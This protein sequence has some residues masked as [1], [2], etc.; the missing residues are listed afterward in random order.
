MIN[1]IPASGALNAADSPAAAPVA[2]NVCRASALRIRNRSPTMRPTLPPSCTVGPSRPS[3]M[4]A[5][6]V[7]IPP[8]NFT[9]STRHQRTGRSSSSAPSISGIPEPPAS[10]AN[11]RTRK[12]P[13]M[14]NSAE[15]PKAHTQTSH[16]RS[17]K[18]AT[19]P[20]RQLSTALTAFS[21]ATPTSPAS[22]PTT[23][24][25]SRMANGVLSRLSSRRIL[26]RCFARVNCCCSKEGVFSF[27]TC[28]VSS[29]K[30][31]QGFYQRQSPRPLKNT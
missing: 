7:P 19:V 5:P 31:P 12:Y 1:R 10:G 22:V 24:A 9:G 11:L 13:T 21:N 3:T 8:I 6:R 26:T 28:S 29:Y 27:I 18:L 23:A 20:M 15:R 16:S 30:R 25:A 17:A 4:P 14:A 2:S